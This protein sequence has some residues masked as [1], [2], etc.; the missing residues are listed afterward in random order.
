MHINL[1]IVYLHLN[2]PTDSTNQ[3]SLPPSLPPSLSL[4]L[5]QDGNGPPYGLLQ[6][7]MDLDEIPPKEGQLQHLKGGHLAIIPNSTDFFIALSD[8]KEWGYGHTVAGIIGDWLA[9]E[10]IGAQD[11]DEIKHESFGTVMRMM[12]N[13]VRFTLGKA[14]NV[15]DVVEL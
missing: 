8:H 10:L 4:P 3:P 11:Y 1:P 7:K 14:I 13:P 9:V 2:H 15:R 12:R 6:G 5:T